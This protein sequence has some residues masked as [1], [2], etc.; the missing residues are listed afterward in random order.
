MTKWRRDRAN[1]SRR[2]QM[3]WGARVPGRREGFNDFLVLLY[4]L[5]EGPDLPQPELLKFSAQYEATGFFLDPAEAMDFEVSLWRQPK[6]SPL[7]PGCF[8]VQFE[9]TLDMVAVACTELFVSDVVLVGGPR[10]PLFSDY[11]PGS[12]VRVES[13]DWAIERP[14][15]QQRSTTRVIS[16][17]TAPIGAGEREVVYAH[18]H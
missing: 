13:L 18:A 1:G 3:A 17:A 7:L 12:V 14:R 2:L 15:C 9:A 10:A 11:F 5:E 4:S 16:E 6:L 8:T